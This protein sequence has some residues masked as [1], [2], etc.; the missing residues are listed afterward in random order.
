M[1]QVLASPT[2]TLSFW[3]VALVGVFALAAMIAWEWRVRTFERKRDM[4]KVAAAKQS[5]RV[6]LIEENDDAA[7]FVTMLF[8]QLG[9]E[10][11]RISSVNHLFVTHRKRP[12]DLIVVDGSCDPAL[13]D[14][15]WDTGVARGANVVFACSEAFEAQAVHAAGFRS[16]RKPFRVMDLA[17]LL[18]E[19]QEQVRL[20][21]ESA[22]APET[23]RGR[24]AV[25]SS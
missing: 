3:V 10:V 16:V 19:S 7:A 21:P 20:R 9:A 12:A 4:R 18:A 22:V 6:L 14:E 23:A 17:T 11:E 1:A 24:G 2:L 5:K 25:A 15:V 8:A 13:V